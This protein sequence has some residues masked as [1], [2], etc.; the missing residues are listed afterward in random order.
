ME[1][2]KLKG[3]DYAGLH[4]YTRRALIQESVDII[5]RNMIFD[6]PL[7]C[8][9]GEIDEMFPK[10]LYLLYTVK[11]KANEEYTIFHIHKKFYI[12]KTHS[13]CLFSLPFIILSL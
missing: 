7:V 5:V 11:D 3:N 8:I 9:S 6:K 4:K 1:I 13:L 10:Y 12:N 2:C